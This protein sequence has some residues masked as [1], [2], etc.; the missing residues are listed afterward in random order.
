MTEPQTPE[1]FA[2]ALDVRPDGIHARYGHWVPM[3]RARD[4]QVRAAALEEAAKQLSVMNWIHPAEI[5]RALA[6]RA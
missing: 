6:R 3:I 5:V 1:E 2:D 4:A